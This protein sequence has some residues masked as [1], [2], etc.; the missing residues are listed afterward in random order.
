MEARKKVVLT[1]DDGY[2]NCYTTLYP[3]LKAHN[4]PAT[5]FLPTAYIRAENEKGSIAWYD[6]VPFCISITKKEKIKVNGKDYPLHNE[7]E[8]IAAILQIK[9][10]TRD[11][12]HQRR[13]ILEEVESQT[14]VKAKECKKEDFLFISWGECKEMQDNG[15][16][17]GSHTV[18]H[19]V[20]TMQTREEVY[21]EL[22]NSKSTIE[23][24]LKEKCT[25][26][27][28]PFGNNNNE[29]RKIMHKTG[30]LVGLTTDYGYNTK[31]TDTMQLHR[32]TVS[33]KSTLSLFMLTLL[34]NFPKVHHSMY[35]FY[36]KVNKMRKFPLERS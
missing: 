24:K 30:Y 8:K 20:L 10:S 3:I 34:F 35:V 14:E 32:I 5:I 19:Q 26:M 23:Q 29:I 28:Y 4:A 31:E 11:L 27:A 17:F 13:R 22:K 1:F 2:K 12:P 18:T 9:N 36:S 15:I 16:S 21:K 7:K 33:N 25:T 6:V